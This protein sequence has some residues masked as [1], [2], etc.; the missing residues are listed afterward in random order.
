MLTTYRCVSIGEWRVEEVGRPMRTWEECESRSKV[1]V[2]TM[3]GAIGDDG[4]PAI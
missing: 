2:N 3:V 1:I 4:S